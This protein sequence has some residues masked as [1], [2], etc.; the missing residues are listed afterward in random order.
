MLS[1]TTCITL[2]FN[3]FWCNHQPTWRCTSLYVANPSLHQTWWSTGLQCT[4]KFM[5]LLCFLSIHPYVS[6]LQPWI[7]HEDFFAFANLQLYHIQISEAASQLISAGPFINKAKFAD[8]L[9]DKLKLRDVGGM[10]GIPKCVARLS[11]RL[12]SALFP[13]FLLTL[14]VFVFFQLSPIHFF[15][16]S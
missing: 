5:I 15:L 9:A 11:H 8:A 12:M 6:I 2:F 3:F 13:Y 7:S 4:H 14:I 10:E 1:F 16:W